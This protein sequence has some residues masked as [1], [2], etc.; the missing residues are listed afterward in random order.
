M[1]QLLGVLGAATSG[2]IV[3]MIGFRVMKVLSR[4]SPPDEVL[5]VEVLASLAK[6]PPPVRALDDALAPYSA[7]AA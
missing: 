6:L 2:G 1:T 4:R 3:G 5:E 7:H